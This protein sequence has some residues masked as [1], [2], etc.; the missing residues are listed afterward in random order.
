MRIL[1][2][3]YNNPE[4]TSQQSQTCLA[5]MFNIPCSNPPSLDSQQRVCEAPFSDVLTGA[6][7]GAAAGAASQELPSAQSFL[8]HF[9]RSTGRARSLQISTEAPQLLTLQTCLRFQPFTVCTQKCCRVCSLC[10]GTSVCPA[11]ASSW[12]SECP[13]A[14]VFGRG[15]L[16]ALPASALRLQPFILVHPKLET[17]RKRIARSLEALI[18]GTWLA[19]LLQ[20]PLWDVC[21]ALKRVALHP[22]RTSQ[23]HVGRFFARLARFSS[24]ASTAHSGKL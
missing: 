11:A 22:T 6:S 13:V 24:V 8:M 4:P 2:L 9:D 15:W 20:L 18:R 5:P 12:S 14:G 1:H 17:A 3:P 21:A 19:S 10:S 23:L 16:H 7:P